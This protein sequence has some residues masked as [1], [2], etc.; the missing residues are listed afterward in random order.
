[1]DLGFR[2]STFV[3]HGCATAIGDHGGTATIGSLACT[4]ALAKQTPATTI[5]STLRMT[6]K[7][8]EA[9]ALAGRSATSVDSTAT[10]SRGATSRATVASFSLILTTHQ[11]DPDDREKQRDAAQKYSIHTEPSKDSTETE[12]DVANRA[13]RSTIGGRA[14]SRKASADL[15]TVRYPRQTSFP[16][17]SESLLLT[18]SAS[19]IETRSIG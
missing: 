1:M 8:T 15:S 14:L 9:T 13:D 7:L 16:P 18:E 12:T 3:R 17:R 5:T 6:A 19:T 2:G 10:G 4:T 11:G